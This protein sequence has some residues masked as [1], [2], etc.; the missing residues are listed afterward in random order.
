M[1]IK[2][3]KINGKEVIVNVSSVACIEEST[4]DRNST[5]IKLIDGST[6]YI[7]QSFA[8]IENMLRCLMSDYVVDC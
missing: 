3:T 2:L 8:E 4:M 1:C 5:I 6:L 7:K